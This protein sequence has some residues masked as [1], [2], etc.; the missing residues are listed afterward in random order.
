[1]GWVWCTTHRTHTLTRLRT[2][3][4]EAADSIRIFEAWRIPR[5]GDKACRYERRHNGGNTCTIKGSEKH[6]KHHGIIIIITSSFVRSLIKSKEKS[7]GGLGR[8][9]SKS[10]RKGLIIARRGGKTH[11]AT[12]QQLLKRLLRRHQPRRRGPANAGTMPQRIAPTFHYTPFS[13]FDSSRPVRSPSRWGLR[14]VGSQ[15]SATPILHAFLRRYYTTATW[16]ESGAVA[17]LCRME[18][19]F[20]GRARQRRAP[21]KSRRSSDESGDESES[22]VSPS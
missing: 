15:F 4:H 16:F 5:M 14:C 13:L 18:A 19:R 2:R 17:G 12:K 8:N 20:G 1:M 9:S 3:K 6:S 10:L 7:R 22:L 21:P 11:L